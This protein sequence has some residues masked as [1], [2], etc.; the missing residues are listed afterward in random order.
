MTKIPNWR[1]RAVT[2]IL[3]AVA[4]Y[5]ANA[6]YNVIRPS[7]EAGIATKQVEDSVVTYSLV[8]Q[9]LT[10]NPVSKAIGW[11]FLIGVLLIWG[12]YA[13]NLLKR[14]KSDTQQP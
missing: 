7:F 6:A 11:I 5:A 8:Q 1:W 3:L 2:T 12:T 13:L 10:G 4:C 9:L 14:G